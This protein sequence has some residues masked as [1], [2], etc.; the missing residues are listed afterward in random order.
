MFEWKGETFC[1]TCIP[2]GISNGPRLFTRLC[3]PMLAYLQHQGVEIVIYIDGTFLRA[4][5]AQELSQRLKITMCTLEGCGFLINHDK[6]VL[7]P[8]QKLEFLGFQ[9]DTVAFTISLLETKQSKLKCMIDNVL[10]T[11]SRKMSIHHLA[12]IIGTMVATFPAS[13]HAQLHYRILECFK[14]KCLASNSFKWTAKIT[15]KGNCI[16]ELKWWSENIF[17]EKFSRSLQVPPVDISLLTDACDYGF[18]HIIHEDPLQGVFSDEQKKLSINTKELLAIYFAFVV[19]KDDLKNKHILICSDSTTALSCIRKKGSDDVIRD[20]ITVRLFEL[21]HVYNI[22]ISGTHISGFENSAADRASRIF[23]DINNANI[24]WSC[25]QEL[26]N[27]MFWLLPFKLKIDLFASD[28]NKK[29]DRFCSWLPC[30]NTFQ[31]D[32]FTLN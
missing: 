16:E 10:L 7:H 27:N 19:C 15:L 21:A 6:S 1:Y 11:P 32:A 9:I 8:T 12:K 3:K 30:T 14:M 17:T 23:P 25:P 26:V 20:R 4:P 18:V 29:I 31:V 13:L 2:N 22:T 24:E 28:S 5:S